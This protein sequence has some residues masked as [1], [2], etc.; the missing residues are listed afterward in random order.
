ME[1]LSALAPACNRFLTGR[2]SE[3]RCHSTLSGE[4]NYSRLPSPCAKSPQAEWGAMNRNSQVGISLSEALSKVAANM[5]GITVKVGVSKG[6]HGSGTVWRHGLI[7]TN[8]H[9]AD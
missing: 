7:V 4:G 8:A 6:R 3:N 5:R 2:T 1:K 9:V